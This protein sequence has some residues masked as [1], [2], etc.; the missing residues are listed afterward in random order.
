MKVREIYKTYNI[1]KGLAA[2]MLRV[3][4]VAKLICEHVYEANESAIVRACL[5]HDMGNLLKVKFDVSPE[6][7]EPEGVGFWQEIQDAMRREYGDDVHEATIAMIRQ[8][9]T[10]E[11]VALVQSMAFDHIHDIARGG[12]LDV[13]IALYADMRV[14]LHGV[15]SL[16][17]RFDDIEARYV[18]QRF[19]SEELQLRRE[20]GRRIEEI[21][22]DDIALSPVQI[23][24]ES[25]TRMHQ[26][27]LE[28]DF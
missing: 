11:V 8:V 23:T 4:S 19:S 13:Q 24:E 27:L 25:T 6:Q 16:D 2:H 1:N 12:N 15:V 17:E 20:A 10:N 26:Q 18:P 3:A 22:F 7:F 14:G 28:M 5:V 9:A 21:V